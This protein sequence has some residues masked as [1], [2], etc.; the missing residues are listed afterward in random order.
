MQNLAPSTETD[1]PSYRSLWL[2]HR[3]VIDTIAAALAY[4]DGFSLK[5]LETAA[6]RRYLALGAAA[7]R[8]L[9]EK[10]LLPKE[11]PEE[12]LIEVEELR[13]ELGV[14]EKYQ[15]K[16]ENTVAELRVQ[17]D[18]LGEDAVLTKKEVRTLYESLFSARYG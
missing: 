4:E 18:V 7:T 5:S 11:N 9:V 6:V 8:A 10:G 12:L 13:E 15:A 2:D 14:C 16:I 3:D 1:A 17:L